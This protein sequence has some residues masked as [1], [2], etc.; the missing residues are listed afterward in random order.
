MTESDIVKTMQK[1]LVIS[2]KFNARITLLEK[3]IEV[4]SE[5]LY[6]SDKSRREVK[7]TSKKTTS[8]DKWIQ[9]AFNVNYDIKG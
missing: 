4:M 8:K 6:K 2:S 7:T 3:A 5:D 1:M 9:N